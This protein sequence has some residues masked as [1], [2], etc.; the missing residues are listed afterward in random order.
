MVSSGARLSSPSRAPTSRSGL[1]AALKR[2]SAWWRESVWCG[3]Q[4]ERAA[5]QRRHR[6]A[7]DDDG[8]AA[9]PSKTSCR[10]LSLSSALACL[11][12]AGSE[13]EDSC[14][15]GARWLGRGMMHKYMR[16]RVA[17]L[18]R[19]VPWGRGRLS[20]YGMAGVGARLAWKLQVHVDRMS[21]C[22][23]EGEA[24]G[25]VVWCCGA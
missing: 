9:C 10:T 4:P 6:A 25:G 21:A 23:L 19:S 2:N 5:R 3:V 16:L 8:G 22:G 24:R 13:D 14:L 12:R 7:D 1:C 15:C 18:L 17:C 20:L 11:F